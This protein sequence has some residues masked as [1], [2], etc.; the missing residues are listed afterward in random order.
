MFVPSQW[1]LIFSRIALFSGFTSEVCG[2]HVDGHCG[3]VSA[4]S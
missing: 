2:H 4:C 1:E 3:V